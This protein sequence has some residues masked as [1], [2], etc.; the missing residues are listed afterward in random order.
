MKILV[1]F[2]HFPRPKAKMYGTKIKYHV[3]YVN[4]LEQ[5]MCL[6]TLHYNITIYNNR[7]TQ[8]S[9]KHAYNIINSIKINH[10]NSESFNT[11]DNTKM[12]ARNRNHV[13]MSMFTY[14]SSLQKT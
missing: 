9:L 7:S 3:I 11:I 6:M 8:I 13:F 1:K 10:L 12:E 14:P 2:L 5:T 4:T